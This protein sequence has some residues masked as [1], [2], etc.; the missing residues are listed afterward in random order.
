MGDETDEIVFEDSDRTYY[1]EESNEVPLQTA[2]RSFECPV[3]GDSIY[4][5][6]DPDPDSLQ[7]YSDNTCSC[8]YDYYI[9]PA[10]VTVARREHRDV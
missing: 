7:Y 10:T 8:G 6:L 4:W 3:C 1:D 2:L 5:V 9:K